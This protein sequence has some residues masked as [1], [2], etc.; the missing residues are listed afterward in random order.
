MHRFLD[1]GARG[2]LIDAARWLPERRIP[3]HLVLA[4]I[5]TQGLSILVAGWVDDVEMI[6]R[7][8][9]VGARLAQAYRAT[10]GS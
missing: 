5:G 7:V 6:E 8:A 4:L 10:V 1:A 9:I 3:H 2:A